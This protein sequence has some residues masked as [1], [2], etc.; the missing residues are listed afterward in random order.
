[1]PKPTKKAGPIEPQPIPQVGDKVTVPPSDSVREVVH[2]SRD[3]TEVTLQ[4]L[5]SNLQWLRVLT[6][7]LKFVDRKAPPRTDN[8]FTC[9]E[10]LFDAA[11]VLKRITTVQEENSQR[12]AEDVA[13][14]KKY[15]KTQKVPSS[16]MSVLD[17]LATIHEQAWHE[18]VEEIEGLLEE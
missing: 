9:P 3:G 11:E 1:M 7:T 6:E 14:L 8:P 18:A 4:A 5:N 16:V 17:G 10:S 13:I 12:F 2:V 15:L